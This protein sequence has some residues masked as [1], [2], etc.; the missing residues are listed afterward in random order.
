M[1]RYY[2]IEH[3]DDLYE[4][5]PHLERLEELQREAEDKESLASVNA[6]YVPGASGEAEAIAHCGGADEAM[7]GILESLAAAIPE[8]IAGRRLSLPNSDA[9]KRARHEIQSIYESYRRAAAESEEADG[10]LWRVH[11]EDR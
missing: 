8:A 9:G 2:P 7:Y 5:P 6:Q 3:V 4:P 1:A 11:Q 10:T